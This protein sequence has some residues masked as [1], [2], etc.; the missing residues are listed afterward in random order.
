VFSRSRLGASAAHPLG[1]EVGRGVDFSFEKAPNIFRDL[2]GF[3]QFNLQNRDTF[4][5]KDG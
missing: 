5:I 3:A 4:S 2:F 1:R